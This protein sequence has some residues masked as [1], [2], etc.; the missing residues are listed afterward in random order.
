MCIILFHMWTLLVVYLNSNTFVEVNLVF[1]HNI[2]LKHNLGLK[3]HYATE[4]ILVLL[5]QKS[6]FFSWGKGVRLIWSRTL[7]GFYQCF[8]RAYLASP[9][10]IIW[11]NKTK[12]K[13]KLSSLTEILTI[14]FN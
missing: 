2:R 11:S 4:K 8:L 7:N 12:S 5:I 13:R 10:F 9:G 3:F 6:H 14:N 1:G